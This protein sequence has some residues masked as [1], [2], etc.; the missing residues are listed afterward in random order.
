[1]S[2]H[3]DNEPESNAMRGLTIGIVIGTALWLAA[4]WA[5]GAV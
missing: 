5:T 2:T 3:L 1:M 4:M